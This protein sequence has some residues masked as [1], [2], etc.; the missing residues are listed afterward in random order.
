MMKKTISF[1][2]LLVTFLMFSCSESETEPT[3]NINSQNKDIRSQIFNTNW[4]NTTPDKAN[5]I[6]NFSAEKIYD[7]IWIYEDEEKRYAGEIGIGD[8][9]TLDDFSYWEWFNPSEL[10]ELNEAY[11]LFVELYLNP[12]E[13]KLGT[14]YIIQLGD[15]VISNVNTESVMGEIMLG[16]SL[17][18]EWD[19]GEYYYLL[20]LDEENG[21]IEYSFVYRRK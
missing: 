9:G 14:S 7:N 13:K 6:V 16:K 12:N 2:L 19:K 11:Q 4:P 15:E 8:Y 20:F 10:S 1:F 3:S 21:N 17:K 5:S 18:Y